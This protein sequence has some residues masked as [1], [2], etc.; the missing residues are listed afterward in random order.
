LL[1]AIPAVSAAKAAAKLATITAF[2]IEVS[3]C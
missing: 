1:G 3:Y 2:C